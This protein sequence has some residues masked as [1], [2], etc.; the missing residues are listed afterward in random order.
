MAANPESKKL[1]AVL[2]AAG[3]SARLGQPKQMVKIYGQSLVRRA[4]IQL[5]A[6]DPISLT[7]VTGSDADAVEKDLQDLPLGITQN[8]RWDQG[9][10]GS[11]ACG[12]RTAAKEADGLMIVLCD[13][14]KVD[15]DDLGR[16][17]TAWTSDI[18]RIFCAQWK[19]EESLIYGPPAI[20]PRIL[21]RELG[22]LMGDRGAKPLI[23]ANRDIASFVPMVN[24]AYD[25]DTAADLDGLFRQAGPNPSS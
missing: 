10:G 1:A 9:M 16:L 2:L 7:V 20:F 8:D 23:S 11:I 21:I 18:S 14:W 17:V 22:E 4:A 12:A 24:A 19:G 25:L 3:G 6:L 15:Q 13:Q 5:L